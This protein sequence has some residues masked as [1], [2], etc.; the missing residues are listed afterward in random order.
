MQHE[1]NHADKELSRI[2]AEIIVHAYGRLR[3]KVLHMLL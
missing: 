1:M 2:T 3:E